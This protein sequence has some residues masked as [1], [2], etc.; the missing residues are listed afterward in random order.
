MQFH[1]LYRRESDV[2]SKAWLGS[3]SPRYRPNYTMPA[4]TT[5]VADRWAV[6]QRHLCRNHAISNRTRVTVS[7]RFKMV[8]EQFLA[9]FIQLK[10]SASAKYIF[11]VKGFFDALHETDLG[12]TATFG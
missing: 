8:H 2:V 11:A 5:L 6:Q 10:N 12:R 1:R 3:L 9:L 7:P 4:G